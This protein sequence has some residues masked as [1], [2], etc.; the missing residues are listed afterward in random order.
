MSFAIAELR[1]I[2]I[3]AH[4]DAGKTTA[5]ERILFY[6]G[7]SHK[8]GEVHEGTAVMDWMDQEQ[9]RG[10]TITSAATTCFWRD[11]QINIIDTPGHVDFTVEVERSLRVLD[12]AVAIFSA[13][14]GVEAQSETVWRQADRYEVPRIA[15]VNKMDRV[16]ADF[17]AVLEQIS[18]KL[19]ARPV[20]FQLPLGAEEHH[21]GV[22]DL[23][24]MKAVVY[25]DSTL[26]AQYREVSIPDEFAEI[27]EEYR[28]TLMEA[29]VEDDDD[30]AMRYLEGEEIGE[31]ELKEAARNACISMRFVPC[32]CGSAFKNKGV[33]P[34]LDAV[35]DYL[36]SPL[37]VPPIVGVSPDDPDKELPRPPD[38]KAP[39]A[40]LAFK[41]M[42]DP[43]VG[44]L[45]YLRVYSGTA[46]A[47]T[48]LF[49]SSRRKRERL[50]RILKMHANK[51]EDVK[52]IQ[53]G[54]IVAAVG[55][56]HTATGD[57]LSDKRDVVILES[58]DFPDT[59]ISIAIEPR[60]KADQDKLGEA[61]QRIALEDPTFKI[62]RDPETGQ[63]L[64][65]G[66]GELH[67]E[68]IVTR[69]LRE[70]NV[71]AAV[72]KPQVAYRESIGGRAVGEARFE[73]QT[74]GR[75]QYGHVKLRLEPMPRGEGFEFEDATTGGSV[76]KEFVPAVREGVEESLER[77]ALA[78]FPIIDLKATLLGGSYHDVDSSELSFKIASSMAFDD[79]LAK[80]SPILIEPIMDLEV[81]MPE[82]YLGSVINDLN[83]RRG[84]VSSM[85]MRGGAQVVSAV[86]PLAAMFGYATAL[87]SLTQ[88]R[89]TFTMQFDHLAEVPG[90]V[91][92]D[93]VK[94][95]RG[96]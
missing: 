34:L 24:G 96:Y 82:E 30:L 27:A 63:T 45:T 3:M 73:R 70:F 52:T 11:H 61:L 41:I 5:T 59:V 64:I 26:G 57:T 23:L 16:G 8:M 48:Q 79:A 21:Q 7:V 58:M 81:S 93:V 84:K 77:G 15:F 65:A 68:I 54:D 94:K 6:T 75:G 80:A 31:D 29:I 66:M 1:N 69:L 4:I 20:A 39:L 25:D 28:E 43:Y 71:G 42:F 46:E 10:I 60:T 2:G 89:A 62:R 88:G 40:A 9:E 33:Q 37:D 17:V 14:E 13:V 67:L 50:G 18:K 49:N 78:D 51:R 90:G 38:P 91:A 95:L 36:P 53:A 87:R 56:K 86:V 12:G 92:E 44:N 83:G 85:E 76:P 35:I 19:G 74:G 47:G 55:F 22:I 32:F 72:G